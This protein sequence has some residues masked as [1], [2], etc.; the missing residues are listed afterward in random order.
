MES[1]HPHNQQS[2]GPAAPAAIPVRPPAP[3]THGAQWCVV[4]RGRGATN[5]GECTRCDRTGI[6]PLAKRDRN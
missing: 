2:V 4:C 6:E 3:I 5:Y 1:L